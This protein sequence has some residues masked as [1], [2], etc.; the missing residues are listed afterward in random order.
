MLVIT[1]RATPAALRRSGATTHWHTPRVAGDDA[2]LELEP[3]TPRL[4]A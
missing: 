3:E 1:V 4:A 2:E